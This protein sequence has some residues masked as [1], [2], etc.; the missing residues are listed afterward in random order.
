[1]TDKASGSIEGDMTADTQS[2]YLLRALTNFKK[3]ILVISPDFRILAA[4]GTDPRVK[5]RQVI[6]QTC[7]RL[8]HQRDKPCKSCPAKRVLS[9]QRHAYLDLRPEQLRLE[10]PLDCFYSYPI[11]EKD[12][13]TAIAVFNFEFPALDHLQDELKRTNAF[14]LNLIQS[15]CDGIIAADP[16]GKVI[17]FNDI[18]AQVLGYS[19]KEALAGLNI[20]DIYEGDGAREVM[21]NL[22]SADCGGV[23]KIKKYRVSLVGKEGQKIPISLYAAI[24]YEGE[25]EVATLGFFH[26]LRERIHIQQ[27]L[28]KTQVQLM[29]S[30]K[31]AS[32]GKLAAGVAHQLNNPLGSITLYAKL[33]LEEHKLTPEAQDDIERILKDAERCRDTVRE[34]LEFA[35]QNRQFMKPQAINQALER[36]LR[37]V[38]N[39]TLLQNIRIE[40]R[41]A[42]DLPLV[43]AD[44]H[45]LNHMFMNLIINAAQAMEGKGRLLLQTRLNAEA[46]AVEIVIADSGPGIPGDHINHIF[47]PFYTTKAEGKG[48]GLGLSVVYGIV[49]NHG[50][51]ISVANAPPDSDGTGATFTITLPLTAKD[52]QG[53]EAHG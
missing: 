47:E 8:L 39:Q 46:Q 2:D 19:V 6:G 4:A 21:R 41:L 20:R 7:H 13:L 15:A 42:E 29:Q 34:L 1:M 28:E 50:G 51:T 18:A 27:E 32:L 36:T 52:A 53:E 33:V 14:L 17:L 12:A 37:L 44:A 11:V 48:T 31:M 22:R 43:M 23:G 45:Q 49:E 24:V 16:S 10:N 9:S 26:D 35:R 25:E 40:K 38:E 5:D 3:R 30:E